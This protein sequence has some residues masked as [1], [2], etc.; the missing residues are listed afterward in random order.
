MKPVRERRPRR[1]MIR[2]IVA[3]GLA[4]GLLAVLVPGAGAT[5]TEHLYWSNSVQP[6]GLSVGPPSTA[7]TLSS[8]NVRQGFITDCHGPYGLAIGAPA[9]SS[10]R[11]TRT[12]RSG[13]PASTALT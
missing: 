8:T 2:V 3:V 11:T 6:R 4:A 12:P 9:V 1:R 5:D 10:G 7:P 13:A